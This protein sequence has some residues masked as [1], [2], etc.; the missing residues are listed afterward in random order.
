MLIWEKEDKSCFVNYG[1]AL[2]MGR[3]FAIYLLQIETGCP[4]KGGYKDTWE[5]PFSRQ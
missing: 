2:I 4:G 1:L 3:L 5:S